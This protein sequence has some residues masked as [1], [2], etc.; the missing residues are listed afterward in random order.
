MKCF[1]QHFLK[2]KASG[3]V[4]LLLVGHRAHCSSP[5][6]LQAAVENNITI[7]CLPSHCTQA[8]QPLDKCFLGPLKSHFKNSAAAWMKQNLQRKVTRYHMA[9]LIGFAWNG[10]ASVGVG[11]NAFQSTGIYALNRNRV[12]EYFFY[13]SDTSETVT[14]METAPPDIAP[15]CAPST[16]GTNSA[17]TAVES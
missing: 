8:L 11:L 15:I 7:I 10:A 14:F 2:H 13:I 1:T 6:L 4:V 5:L 3:K 16:S 12:P 9:S 17:S